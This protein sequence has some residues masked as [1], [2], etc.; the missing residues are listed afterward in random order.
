MNVLY[1]IGILKET[2][3][4]TF[5]SLQGGYHSQCKQHQLLFRDILTHDFHG[6]FVSLDNESLHLWKCNGYKLNFDVKKYTFGRR[7]SSKCMGIGMI[8]EVWKANITN[9]IW[10][11]HYLYILTQR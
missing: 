2:G 8:R 3:K 10:I 1:K 7:G 4:K 6:C 9:Q 5:L 11:M